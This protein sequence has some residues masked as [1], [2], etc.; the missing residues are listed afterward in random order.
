MPLHRKSGR[1]KGMNINMDFRNDANRNY[2]VIKK[3]SQQSAGENSR[4]KMIMKNS[5]KSL[6]KM[7]VHN[8]DDE[9]LYYYEIQ[10]KLNLKQMFDGREIGRSEL[11]AILR[12]IVQLFNELDSY[13]LSTSYVK[14]MP[15]YIWVDPD[16]VEPV[17]TFDPAAVSTQDNLQEQFM[18]LAQFIIDNADKDDRE[19]T[20]MAYE[21]F[22]MVERR[23][24]SP[25][26][27]IRDIIAEPAADH[28]KIDEITKNPE[29]SA[30][31][32][33]YWRDDD[34][35]AENYFT[36]SNDENSKGHLKIALACLGLVLLAG[37]VYLVLVLNPYI[38]KAYRIT[39]VEYMA[40][41]CVIAVLFAVAL[42][43]T[44]YIYNRNIERE[45]AESNSKKEQSVSRVEKDPIN[46]MEMKFEPV[47]NTF[48]D[49]KTELLSP[50]KYGRQTASLTGSI[51]GGQLKFDIDR[52]PFVLGKKADRVDGFINDGSV[53]RLHASIKEKDGRYFISDMNSTNGTSVNG[54]RL[55]INET[56]AL[57]DGDT[58]SIAGVMMTFRNRRSYQAYGAS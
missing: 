28:E 23:V 54:R 38:L 19:C 36:E 44:V 10:S 46:E 50:R 27:I 2:M 6:L 58:V 26:G 53:S 51:D 45:K 37:A 24:Y 20:A 29:K 22:S 14:F 49:E 40:I 31:E 12:G 8:I 43:I 7:N 52:N 48:A 25:E 21:Y 3:E 39:D 13:L 41:G 47:R 17:F 9:V 56:T 1:K 30:E 42:V 35:D 34:E 11:T 16:T 15:E 57:E 32:I 5:M 18:E 55:E 33:V 4:E